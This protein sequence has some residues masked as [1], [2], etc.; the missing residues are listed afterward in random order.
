MKI[1]LAGKFETALIR[2]VDEVVQPPRNVSTN[3]YYVGLNRKVTSNYFDRCGTFVALAKATLIPTVDW[4]YPYG[5]QYRGELEHVDLGIEH[6][7]S[8]NNEWDKD[9]VTF[10]EALLQQRALSASSRAYISNL[11]FTHYPNDVRKQMEKNS[12]HY[13]K[14]AAKHYLCRLFLQLKSARERG[15][16]IVLSEDDVQILREVG[17]W[18]TRGKSP[19]TFDIPDLTGKLIEPEMFASG[20]L[21]FSPPDIRSVAAV[22]SDKHI[23]AYAKKISSLI[24]ENPSQGRERKMLAAMVDAH[25]KSEAGKRAE[26]VFEVMSWL[27]KPLH[28]VPGIDAALSIAE[29]AK[30]VGVKLLERGI[31]QKDWHLIAVKMT[32]IALRDY[33]NRKSNLL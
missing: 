27:V 11:T 29:D 15:A 17:L 32:D 5:K 13:Q 8:K 18:M 23:R 20:L 9:T 25:E 33:L 12:K 26:K 14:E 19:I 31:S 16:Y 3:D 21:N 28:Y 10:V 24:E 6:A 4:N 1:I 7:E 22:R 30:D 2:S